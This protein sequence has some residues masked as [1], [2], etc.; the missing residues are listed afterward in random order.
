MYTHTHITPVKNI[1]NTFAFMFCIVLNMDANGVQE[2][3][4]CVRYLA[5]ILLL[6]HFRALIF[7]STNPV[8]VCLDAIVA[9]LA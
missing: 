3:C 5:S 6:L 7:A 2:S 4:T 1:H 8:K 9:W